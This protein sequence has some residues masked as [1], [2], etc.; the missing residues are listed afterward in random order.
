MAFAALDYW[1]AGLPVPS[2]RAEDFPDRAVPSDGTRLAD[3]I[4]KR[5]FDSYA[6]WSARQFLTWSLAEDHPTWWSA[7]VARLTAGELPRVRRSLDAGRPVVLGLIAARTLEEV[8]R[9]RQVVAYGYDDDG[10]G[11]GGGAPTRLFVHDSHHPDTEVLLGFEPAGRHWEASAG[12]APGGGRSS[13]TTPASALPTSTSGRPRA[14]GSTPGRRPD[15]AGAGRG[16]GRVQGQRRLRHGRRQLRR[17][18]RLPVRAGLLAHHP[19]GRAGGGGRGRRHRDPAAPPGPGH[20][21]RRAD[22]P[23][24][25]PGAGAGP[26]TVEFAVEVIPLDA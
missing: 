16:A 1:F 3:F 21:P 24:P 19:A 14:S 5:L 11:T 20:R 12:G 15:P 4:H 9:N 17:G 26:W 7:G 6:T 22:P 25:G 13:R 2:H 8:A 23:R 10:A 18:R